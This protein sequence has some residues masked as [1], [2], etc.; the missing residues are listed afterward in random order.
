VAKIVARRPRNCCHVSEMREILSQRYVEGV[1]L[2]DGHSSL[3]P[4]WQACCHLGQSF[5]GRLIGGSVWVLVRA[6]W[7]ST[8]S[9][10]LSAHRCYV[11]VNNR[12][13]QREF[14]N[15]T[16]SSW[17]LRERHFGRKTWHTFGSGS[18]TGHISQCEP[19]KRMLRES[20]TVADSVI[21]LE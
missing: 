4:T 8:S 19:G 15:A 11:E 21:R 10:D 1:S 14:D 3:A 7:S 13:V 16:Q 20:R 18:A 17:P 2:I 9:I 12:L 6:A 5:A